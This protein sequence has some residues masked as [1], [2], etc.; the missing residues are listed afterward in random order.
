MFGREGGREGSSG[1]YC[2]NFCG[3]PLHIHT[4][5]V[6]GSTQILQGRAGC[7]VVGRHQHGV[8]QALCD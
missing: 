5:V 6:I 1:I 4:Y 7:T 2:I 3:A 8:P